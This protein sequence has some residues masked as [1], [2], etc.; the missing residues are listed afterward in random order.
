MSKDIASTL[1]G[2]FGDA[3][4]FERPNEH[5]SEITAVIRRDVE[6]VDEGGQ[7]MIVQWLVRFAHQ[8]L[9][10]KPK[11]GDR[12]TRDD[13]VLELGRCLTDNQSSIEY[14]ASVGS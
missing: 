5:S 8:D 14:E 10:F 4:L 13:L 11:R 1:S 3:V 2:V 12:V 6:I 9:P 7:V